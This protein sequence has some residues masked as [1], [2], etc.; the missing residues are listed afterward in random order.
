MRTDRKNDEFVLN[1]QAYEN[2]SILIAGDNFG[3]RIVAR[4][5]SLGIARPTA[6]AA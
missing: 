4:A 6:F 2:A 1:K 3:L 5:C